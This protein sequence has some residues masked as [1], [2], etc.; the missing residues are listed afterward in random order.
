[1]MYAG[2]YRFAGTV[3]ALRT[4]HHQVHELCADYACPDQPELTLVTTQQ[5]LDFERKK[6]PP[7][8]NWSE[9]Y[10]ET[11]AVYRLLAEALISRGVLLV[12]GSAVAVDGVGYLFTA[13]SGTGKSVH[14]MLWRQVFGSRAVMINDDKP[15][16]AVTKQ[17]AWVYGTPWDGKHRLS[18]NMA[19]PLAGIC[20]LNRGV[21]N[22]IRPASPQ[23]AYPALLRQICR[24]RDRRSLEQ[25]LTLLDTL[26]Q[27]TPLFSMKC[28]MDPQ[29]AQM[30]YE[31]MKGAAR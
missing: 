5:D 2:C 6:N 22:S 8:R 31:A 21:E 16:V 15:L 24:P 11:L 17:G 19:V 28:T 27:H 13:K 4:L 25:E 30:A 3:V 26:T 1:M 9:G 29:A 20:L 10:L 7:D 12:H 18:A 14:T 23:E